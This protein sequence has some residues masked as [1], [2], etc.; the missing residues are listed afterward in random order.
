MKKLLCSHFQPLVLVLSSL[1]LALTATL[2]T[3]PTISTELLIPSN[4]TLSSTSEHNL[5]CLSTLPYS[6]FFLQ[7]HVCERAIL[8]L[9]DT[10]TQGVFHHGDPDDEFSLPIQKTVG[11]CRVTINMSNHGMFETSSWSQINHKA[12]QLNR[13]CGGKHKYR[14]GGGSLTTGVNDNIKI[15]V[16][17]LMPFA[18]A[19]KNETYPV[20]S[21]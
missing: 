4:E 21:E 19:A 13:I 3:I 11:N 14:Y 5:V 6:P 8:Q 2:P 7:Q 10:L 1:T 17:R 20:T 16:E 12:S 15:T 18:E 9:N